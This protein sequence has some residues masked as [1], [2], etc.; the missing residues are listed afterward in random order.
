M[1]GKCKCLFHWLGTAV[2]ATYC[3][4]FFYS[5]LEYEVTLE[6]LHIL[7]I[8]NISVN[9]FAL[10]VILCSFWFFKILCPCAL[11][12]LYRYFVSVLNLSVCSFETNCE[13]MKSAYEQFWERSTLFFLADEFSYSI[14]HFNIQV[15][16]YIEEQWTEHND[17]FCICLFC[18]FCLNV[19]QGD[20]KC[21]VFFFLEV[22]IH[23]N[24]NSYICH[25]YQ[26]FIMK[27]RC[28]VWKVTHYWPQV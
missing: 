7:A 16:I 10:D 25:K 9:N 28:E 5:T 17:Y 18:L 11:I 24:L 23:E 3:L 22:I 21:F 8:L 4:F 13:C 26:L 6:Y 20:H 14:S 27:I 2:H 1:Q 15:L 19:N 12:V